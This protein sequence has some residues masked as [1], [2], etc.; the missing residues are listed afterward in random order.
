MED[1]VQGKVGPGPGR[2][3]W[4]TGCPGVG[5]GHSRAWGVASS[6]D[7]SADLAQGSCSGGWKGEG[8]MGWTLE[9]FGGLL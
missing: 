9:A 1:R 7:L 2:S 8:G 4:R 6:W 5:E 3:V